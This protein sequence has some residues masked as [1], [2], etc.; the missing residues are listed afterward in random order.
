MDKTIELIEELLSKLKKEK[1]LREKAT[2]EHQKMSDQIVELQ[3]QVQRLTDVI[4]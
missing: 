2:T 4:I 3:N 1:D